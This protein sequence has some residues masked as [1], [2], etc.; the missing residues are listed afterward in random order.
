[1][2]G[3]GIELPGLTDDPHMEMT[4]DQSGHDG[5]AFRLNDLNVFPFRNFELPLP[6]HER[7]LFSFRYNQRILDGRLSGTVNQRTTLK[8]FHFHS[9]LLSIPIVALKIPII[10]Q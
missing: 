1:M 3:D 9:F 10:I 7:D 2:D 5:L 6:S 4:V 8:S